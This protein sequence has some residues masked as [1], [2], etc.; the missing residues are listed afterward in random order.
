MCGIAGVLTSAGSAR[1]PLERDATAMADSIA[2]RGPDDHGLWS[3][4]DAGI[5]LTQRRLSIVD[6]SPA[7]HQPMISADGRYVIVFNGEIYNFQDLRPDLEAR[8]SRFRGHSDT[9]VMLEAIAAYGIA[10]TVKRLIGMFAIVVWDRRDRTLT[11]V[12]DRLGIK[13]LYWAK[14]GG[15]FLFG[16]ELKALRAYPGWTARIDRGAVG[17]FMRHNYIPAPHSIYQGVNMLEPGRI[18]TLPWGGEPQIAR[19]WDARAVARAGLADPLRLSD[20]E[21]TDRLEALLLDSV[22]RRMVADVPVGA[23]LS[24]GIDSSTVA[25]LMQAANAG[26]VRT[27]A[28]GFDIAGFNE[29]PQAAAVARHLGTEHTELTVTSQQALDVIPRL[30]DMYDEPFAD[31]SQI[32]TYLVSAM[33]RQHVTVALSGD[34]GDEL[35]AGYNRYQL[36]Q[37]FWRNLALVPRPLRHAAARLMRALPA[38]RWSSLFDL[39][40]HG[41]LPAQAGDK[42]HKLASVL[43]LD[44]VGAI[45]RRLVTHWEPATIMPGIAEP[46]GPL[47]D[48]T[49][50]SDFPG[51]LER[52]QYLDQVTYLPDDIL[53][54]VDRASMA[55]ALEAR[56]PLLDHRVVE[57]AWRIPR[58]DLIR[59]GVSKWPLRQ[60]LYRHVPS[61][62]VDRPKMGFG[63][64][65]GEWL[66]GPLRDWAEALLDKRRLEEAGLVDAATVRRHWQEHLAGQR[67]WQ[68]LLWDV[69]ML[70]AW[71]ERWDSDRQTARP[72]PALAPA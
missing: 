65:L 35:F 7:G 12:R 50:A 27:Y 19:F 39:L 47:W 43:A 56:V 45:Y 54:K 11:L 10:T 33:T 42:L 37:K 68:Y 13:P 62:L 64:P 31:S 69:L 21:L 59:N 48:D 38:D 44:D 60:V 49:I 58:R 40:P 23:F 71:R 32:P 51:G 26:P 34:G 55:V 72:A 30:A 6:L 46:K 57:F 8:G 4:P 29:A 14:F 2:H 28:I 16:S 63:V 24:G 25:A 22:R 1:A 5:A 61:E 18:L 17:A 70:E 41:L 15:L 3:D 53:T 9:E 36:A 52:L 20:R 66:R 67:N